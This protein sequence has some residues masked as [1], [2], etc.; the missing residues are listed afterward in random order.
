MVLTAAQRT[1]FFEHNDQLG[2]PHATFVQMGIEGISNK[3]DLLDFTEDTI[4]QLVD[5]LVKDISPE[6]DSKHV[7][8]HMYIAL[9]KY[10]TTCSKHIIVVDSYR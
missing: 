7:C 10:G 4:K 8:L 6:T 2:I 9:H 3:N 5:N 1:A